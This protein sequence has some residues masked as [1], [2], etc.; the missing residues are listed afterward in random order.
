[1]KRKKNRIVEELINL[2]EKVIKRYPSI[3]EGEERMICRTKNYNYRLHY[4]QYYQT[5]DG[6]IFDV[7]SKYSKTN[8]HNLFLL[9]DRDFLKYYY[10]MKILKYFIED[11][12]IILEK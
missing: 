4:T 7:I 2:M 6:K 12:K 9:L 1:M 11:F 10:K 3:K 5:P 8:I